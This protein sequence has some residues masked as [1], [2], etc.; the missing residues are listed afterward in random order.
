MSLIETGTSPRFETMNPNDAWELFN[1]EKTSFNIKLKKT[2]LD[3][4]RI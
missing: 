2:L 1:H 3:V 4:V